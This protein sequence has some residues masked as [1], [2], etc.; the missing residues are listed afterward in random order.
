MSYFSKKKKKNRI[1]Q[2]L[3]IPIPSRDRAQLVRTWETHWWEM[4]SKGIKGWREHISL[5]CLSFSLGLSFSSLPHYL[6]PL[7]SALL[8]FLLKQKHFKPNHSDH[9]YIN[10]YTGQWIGSFTPDSTYF[11]SLPN[12]HFILSLNIHIFL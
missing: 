3:K 11:L 2:F 6:S 9:W 12:C 5:F 8:T 7:I 1:N 10:I 4:Y